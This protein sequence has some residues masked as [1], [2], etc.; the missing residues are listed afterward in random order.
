MKFIC[1]LSVGGSLVSYTVSSDEG[2]AFVAELRSSSERR[3]D[4]PSCIILRRENGDWKAEPAH[5][6]LTPSL[7]HAIEAGG[8]GTLVQP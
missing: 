2:G 1:V 8:A 3:K 4:L 7:I 6:E 5:D